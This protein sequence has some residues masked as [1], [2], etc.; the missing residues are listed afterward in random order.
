M[1]E[2]I[3]RK[4]G[5]TIN[6]YGEQMLDSMRGLC[7]FPRSLAVLTDEEWDYMRSELVLIYG[8]TLFSM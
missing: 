8:D 6:E 5:C 3:E 7:D 4:L 2:A 1:R